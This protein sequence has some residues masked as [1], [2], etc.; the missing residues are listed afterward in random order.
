MEQKNMEAESK[1][2]NWLYI[3]SPCVIAAAFS[4]FAIISSYLDMD[5]SGGWSFLGVIIFVGILLI[6]LGI[7][8]FVKFWVKKALYVWLAESIL[9]LIMIFVYKTYIM[10]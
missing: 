10:G 8:F 9:I 1:K 7:D 5:D 6:I 2:K 4:V 3:I